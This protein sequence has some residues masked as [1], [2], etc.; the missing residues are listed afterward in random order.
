MNPPRQISPEEESLTAEIQKNL[1]NEEVVIETFDTKQAFVPKV[2]IFLRGNALLILTMVGIVAGFA[3]GFGIRELDPSRGALMWLGM[4]GELF[5]RLLKMMILPLIVCTVITGTASLDPKANGKISA[6]AFAYIVSTNVIACAVA[7]FLCLVIKPGVGQL[8]VSANTAEQ[9]PM[10]TQD[11]FADLLRNIFPDNM[12]E[13]TFRKSQTMYRKNSEV[14]ERNTTNGTSIVSSLIA[15]SKYS[16]KADGI[17]VLGLIVICTVV[18]IAMNQCQDKANTLFKFFAGATDVVLLIIRW[19]FWLTPLGVASLIAV[20][21]AGV[22]D[23]SNAFAQLGKF[24]LAVS[25][26]IVLHQFLILP[27][28]LF[29]TTR[30]NPF[31]YL[32]NIVRPCVIGFASTSTAV[33]IPEMLESCEKNKVDSR[34]ARFVIPFCVTLNADGSALYI[35]SAAI[36]IA[37]LT[38]VGVGVSDVIIIGVLTAVAAMAIPSVPS[39]SIVTLVVILTSLNIPANDIALLFA[40]EWFLDRIRTTCNVVSHTFCA[41]VTHKFCQKALQTHPQD[42]LDIDSECDDISSYV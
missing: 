7:I 34:V 6:V 15:L 2:K 10:E 40:V 28:I 19:F 14:V 35:T 12:M 31:K 22:H 13:A 18:G 8:S 1:K 4:P 36:F 9:E 32:L 5:L 42:K 38:G 25:L 17:N 41:A 21:I 30:R 33:A 39:A 23:I 26:G 20:S 3:L 27:F 11:I 16:G 37:Q 24:V 29:A